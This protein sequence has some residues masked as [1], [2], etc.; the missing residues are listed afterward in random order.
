MKQEIN[1]K[2][3]R[4]MTVQSHTIIQYMH[5]GFLGEKRVFFATLMTPGFTSY[6]NTMT[7]FP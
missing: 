6:L 2:K 5:E 4:P 7:V 1:C 3:P